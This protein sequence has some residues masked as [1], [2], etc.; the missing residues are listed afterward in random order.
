MITLFPLRLRIINCFL[1]LTTFEINYLMIRQKI[2]ILHMIAILCVS[3][4]VKPQNETIFRHD[5]G[6][7][8][9]LSMM[10]HDSVEIG[11]FK[12]EKQV[13]INNTI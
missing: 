9:T 4:Y 5:F 12:A 13:C 11:P 2:L 7:G 8:P 1:V 3:S 6:S 10:G